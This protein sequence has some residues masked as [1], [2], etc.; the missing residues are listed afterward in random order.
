MMRL[1]GRPVAQVDVG[2]DP[3]RPIR[4]V[5]ESISSRRRADVEAEPSEVVELPIPAGEQEQG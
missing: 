5:V 4:I 3:D 2:Q 1:A